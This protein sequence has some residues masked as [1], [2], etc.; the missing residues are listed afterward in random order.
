LR[1][2]A[3]LGVFGGVERE[4]DNGGCQHGGDCSLHH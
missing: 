2:E 1:V 4:C 3:S